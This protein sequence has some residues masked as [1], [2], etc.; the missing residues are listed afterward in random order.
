MLLRSCLPL[1]LLACTLAACP[2]DPPDGTGGS[3]GEGPSCTVG[4]LGD[5]AQSPELEVFFYGAD[6]ADHPVADGAV[7]DMIEP[8]QGGRVIYVGAR[9]RNV[10]GCS[11]LLTA[12]LRDPTTNQIRF[13]TRT[14]NLQ[15]E[16]DG[17]GSV[18]PGVLAAYSNIPA[19]QNSWSAQTLYEDGYLLEVKLEDSGGRVAEASFDVRAQCTELSQARPSGPDVLDE[20]LCI[21]REGYQIGDTCDGGGGAG[22][23]GGGQGGAGGAGGA[24]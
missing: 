17:W 7:L 1:I 24:G 12:T 9:A 2:D 8:P 20:C 4:F 21:C 18:Q 10:D 5:Q 13:D 3:G 6:E 15:D 16:G 22:Q 14:A 23:G 19:C 11:V